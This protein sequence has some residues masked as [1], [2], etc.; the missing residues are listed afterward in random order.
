[1]CCFV[2]CAEWEE[3]IAIET[4]LD[5]TFVLTI[6]LESTGNITEDEQSLEEVRTD[7]ANATEVDESRIVID[8][9]NYEIVNITTPENVNIINVYYLIYDVDCGDASWTLTITNFSESDIDGIQSVECQTVT[10][11]KIIYFFFLF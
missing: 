1:M 10:G 4:L 11:K 9:V 2:L 5:D 6:S 7:I 3:S 8:S